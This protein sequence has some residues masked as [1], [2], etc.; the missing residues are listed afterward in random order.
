MTAL[1]VVILL[2]GIMNLAV[3]SLAKPFS[4][5]VSRA[6]ELG[7]AIKEKL[8]ILDRPLAALYE[9]QAAL[10]VV[11]LGGGVGV[12][13]SKVIESVVTVV[14]PA[15]VGADETATPPPLA[16]CRANSPGSGN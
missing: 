12:D 11:R 1:G 15:A 14:T 2:I 7:A 6:P 4:D 10:G 8:L 16:S 5:F 13:H 9:M 3:M